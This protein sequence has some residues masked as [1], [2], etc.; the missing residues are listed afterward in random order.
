MRTCFVI[1]FVV[2]TASFSQQ[3][4]QFSGVHEYAKSIVY[5]DDTNSTFYKAKSISIVDDSVTITPV[6][7]YPDYD[8]PPIN[9]NLNNIY[10]IRTSQGTRAAEYALY[11]GLLMGL[12]SIL[13]IAD[14]ASDPYTEIDETAARNLTI[15]FTVGGALIGGIWGASKHKWKTIYQKD[16]FS[17]NPPV[18]IQYGLSY[19]K[20]SNAFV[21]NISFSG[22]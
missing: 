4:F 20:K 16:T 18:E 5:M 10:T 6:S 2:V 8:T 1:L 9:S 15:G 11:G 12:S 3:T 22:F 14:V 7:E 21:V 13:A 19:S 17:Q